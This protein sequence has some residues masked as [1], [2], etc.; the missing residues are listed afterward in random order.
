LNST[1][2]KRSFVRSL[3]FQSNHLGC[4]CKNYEDIWFYLNIVKNNIPCAIINKNIYHIHRNIK[5]DNNNDIK[6]NKLKTK[7]FRKTLNKIQNVYSGL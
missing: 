3:H 6:F 7:L 1:H 2:T 5:V 4:F